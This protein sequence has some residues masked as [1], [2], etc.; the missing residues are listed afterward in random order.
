M[1]ALAEGHNLYVA[2]LSLVSDQLQEV[3]L[4]ATRWVEEG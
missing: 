2:E 3:A 4:E 1:P